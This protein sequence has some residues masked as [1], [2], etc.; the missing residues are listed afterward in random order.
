[1]I[2]SQ[3]DQIQTYQNMT[4]ANPGT[5]AEYLEKSQRM[6]F[7]EASWFLGVFLLS[8]VFILGLFLR[9]SKRTRSL[10]AF[11]ASLTHELKTPLTSIRLQAESIAEVEVKDPYLTKLTDRLLQDTARMEGEVERSLELARV[12]GG[13]ALF[14]QGVDLPKLVGKILDGWLSHH[15]S[16]MEVNCKLTSGKVF[17]DVSAIQMILKNLLENSL[18]HSKRDKVKIELETSVKGD[19]VLLRYRDN[20]N[21]SDLDQKKLGTLFERGPGSSGA[22][23]GL[24]LVKVLMSKMGGHVTFQSRDGFEAHL[25]F[26]QGDALV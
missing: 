9:D 25:T 13:G 3:A 18:R 20:G 17:G 16:R 23:V 24:Y 5:S 10:Q 19:A 14:N 12:E 11:F 8:S 22:G 1:M 26:K 7:W 21:G 2:L 4:G 6:V 15:Q